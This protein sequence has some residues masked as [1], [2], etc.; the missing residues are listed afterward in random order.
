MRYYVLDENKNPV[1]CINLATWEEWF[2]K[3]NNRVALS[4][5]PYSKGH[6]AITVSTIFIGLYYGDSDESPPIFETMIFGGE[7]DQYQVRTS[8][9][10]EAEAAHLKACRMAGIKGK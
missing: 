5:G 10:A 8:S 4:I 3:N 9:W 1:R 7:H 2:A 6:Q